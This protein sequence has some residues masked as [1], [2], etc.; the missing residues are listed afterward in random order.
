[1]LLTLLLACARQQ[2]TAEETPAET[3]PAEQPKTKAQ[4]ADPSIS[5]YSEATRPVAAPQNSRSGSSLFPVTDNEG[6]PIPV[7]ATTKPQ[8]KP[9]EGEIQNYPMYPYAQQLVLD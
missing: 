9:A 1:M 3:K 5:A 7:I 2:A 6:N 4:E 8:S